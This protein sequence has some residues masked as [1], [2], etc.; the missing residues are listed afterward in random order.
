MYK[1]DVTF[2]AIIDI[3]TFLIFILGFYRREEM[4]GI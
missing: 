3:A 4:Y 2:D 1:S